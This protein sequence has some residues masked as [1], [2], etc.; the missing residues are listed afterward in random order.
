MSTDTVEVS[1]P[2]VTLC[3]L[4]DAMSFAASRETFEIR[5]AV[6]CSRD[7]DKKDIYLVALRGTNRS[8]DKNDVLG[9]FPCIKAFQA[10]SNIY[11]EKV[12]REMLSLIPAKASV[13]LIGHSFG[14]MVAQQISADE[15]IKSS[16]DLL[17]VLAMGSPYVPLGG[18][19]CPLHRF[20]DKADV[21]PWIGHS[22]KANL[23]TDRPVFQSNG[24]FGRP[25][26][27][28]SDSYRNG[29][30]WR[31]YDPF[32]EP[33][34]GRVI[35]VYDRCDKNSGTKFKVIK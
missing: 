23:K 33:N 34:G 13:A 16:F 26:T 5:K 8:F 15:S 10:K 2:E 32:G 27:A 20:V 30:K 1:A 25:L 19:G 35:E 21:I 9:V 14:G 31:R 24:Y 18:R 6:L 22:I 17:N 29:A 12:R 28:H 3:S 4:N 11:F 7:G